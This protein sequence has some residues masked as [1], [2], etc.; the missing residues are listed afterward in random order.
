M[1]GART[2]KP[3]IFRGCSEADMFMKVLLCLGTYFDP[4]SLAQE[5]SNKICWIG[6]WGGLGGWRL[7][8][9]PGSRHSVKIFE[10]NK[11]ICKKFKKQN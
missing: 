3:S 5:M 8:P 4:V 1:V 11:V 7:N 2:K 10:K 9:L 6:V